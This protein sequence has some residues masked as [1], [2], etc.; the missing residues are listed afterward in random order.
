MPL[1]ALSIRQVRRRP[2]RAILTLLGISVGVAS[3]VAIMITVRTTRRSY[4]EMF[5][6]LTGRA[7]LEIVAEALGSFSEADAAAAAR[8]AG[9][10]HAIAVIQKP[11]A[12]LT[13]SGT[14]PAT[15]LGVDVERD[16]L[17]RDYVLRKGALLSE[18]KGALLEAGFAAANDLDVGKSVTLLTNRGTQRLPIVGLLE[19]RGVA[20]SALGAIVV[21]PLPIAQDVFGMG[22]QINSLQLLLSEGAR[23]QD[24][25]AAVSRGL[26]PGLFVQVPAAR[27]AMGQETLRPTETGLTALSVVSLVAGAFVI[28]NT[29]RMNLGER[30]RQIAIL[31]SIGATRRQILSMVL[32]E[33]VV[34]GTV[35]TL[36]GIVLGLL[37]A[38][39][40]V[41]ALLPALGLSSPIL[42]LTAAPF[43]FAAVVGPGISLAASYFPA[44]LASRR[45][46]LPELLGIGAIR[47]ERVRYWPAVVGLAAIVANLFIL[48]AFFN[49]LI[50]SDWLDLYIP[51]GMTS[52]L[53]GSVLVLPLL[54]GP[55]SAVVHGLVGAAF[56]ST[57]R[58]ALKQLRRLPNRTALTVGVLV[59]AMVVTIGMG[60]TI[61]SNIA[62]I[63][64]WHNRAITA[65]FFVRSV[66]P[67]LG[68]MLAPPV[69]AAAR[70]KIARLPGI[71]TVERISF[72]PSH[73]GNEKFLLLAR[74]FESA[75][76]LPLDLE[77]G[78][79]EEVQRRLKEGEVVVASV[80]SKRLGVGP[81]DPIKLPTRKGQ[82]EVRVCGVTTDYTVGGMVFYADWEATKDLLQHEDVD[83]L[84]VC[85]EPGKM[86]AAEEH[87]REFCK[88][89]NLQLQSTAELHAVIDGLVGR[90]AGFLWALMALSFLVASMGIVNTLT[91]NV[92]EQ[93]RQIGVLRAIAMT[94]RQIRRLIFAQAAAVG[95]LALLP[96]VLA[97][98]GLAYLVHL[99]NSVVL[100]NPVG[101]SVHGGFV[102][103]CAAAAV[104]TSIA[105]AIPPAERAARLNVCQALQ[106]E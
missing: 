68:T 88:S 76:P 101:F 30:R 63:E 52:F 38:Q 105:A 60:N 2:G 34:L 59:I 89:E 7:R 10:E 106:Y 96:G 98:I 64:D 18:E 48:I 41:S 102:L 94:R 67:N 75:R 55:L 39:A 74:D 77:K 103:A 104:L 92:L 81:G 82:V 42:E 87:L 97:G 61:L 15:A 53:V 36:A 28:L 13:P 24:V 100:G 66:M 72:F 70:E 11:V 85:A 3:I 51:A 4:R 79:P 23:D 43:L 29:F 62:D 26:P 6:T 32:R 50:P 54:L 86:A 21:M 49:D 57:G 35:G 93:T 14:V 25:E 46:P 44:R 8:V 19:P 95:F 22:R 31:R 56:G 45:A 91:M 16:R 12:I 80:L 20:A 58:L 9:V 17:A 71:E 99:T 27:G 84:L 73:S 5:D 40:M 33:A 90:V 47:G 83:A 65:D 69:D 37:L 1:F 78:D